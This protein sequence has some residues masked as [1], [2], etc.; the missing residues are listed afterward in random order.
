MPF[1]LITL[2]SSRL[3][4]THKSSPVWQFIKYEA[5]QK[6]LVSTKRIA[7]HN[8]HIPIKQLTVHRDDT[9]VDNLFKNHLKMN[10]LTHAKIFTL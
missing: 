1:N 7:S 3:K 8:E 9:V 5:K 10:I 6:I 4:N 2:I